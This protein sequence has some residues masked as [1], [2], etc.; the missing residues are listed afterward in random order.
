MT[1]F[2]QNN[3]RVSNAGRGLLIF[4][5]LIVILAGLKSAQT[6]VAPMLLAVFIAT[7]AATAS[8][9][10]LRKSR[11]VKWLRTCSATLVR[12]AGNTGDRQTTLPSPPGMLAIAAT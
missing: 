8:P 4:A 1:E 3:Q 10:V 9:K 5:A 12:S 7:I 6:I 2:D 11:C